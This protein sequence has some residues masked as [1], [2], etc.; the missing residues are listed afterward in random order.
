M[1]LFH[2]LKS[3]SCVASCLSFLAISNF[4]VVNPAQAFSFTLTNTDF[5]TDSTSGW[6]TVGDVTTIGANEVS[7]DGTSVDP[8]EGNFQAVITN[9]FDSRVDDVDNSDNALSF[10]QS[11]TDPLDAD[12]S[13]STNP[14]NDVQTQLGLPLSAFSID[15]NPEISGFPRTSKEGSAIYQDFDVTLDPGESGFEITFNWAFLTNDGT[16]ALGNQDFAFLSVYDT[17][18]T[19][20][21]IEVLADSSGSISEPTA[22]NNFVQGNTTNYSTSNP[23]TFSVDG[24][25]PGQTYNYRIALGVID[26]D[27][28]DRSSA[29][30]VDNFQIQPVPFKFSPGLGLV[31]MASLIGVDRLR[32]QFQQK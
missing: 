25:T 27:G 24:L 1:T 12:T 16:T 7:A 8:A 23:Y 2:W 9:T 32:R 15:R 19:P 26:V 6:S 28:S 30:L 22:S 17:N 10:N 3:N 20:G 18:L 4:I 5:E 21:A 14:G 13:N 31:F 29:L 11:G